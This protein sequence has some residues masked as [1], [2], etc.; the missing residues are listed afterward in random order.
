M[1]VTSKE[2]M[3]IREGETEDAE[4]IAYLSNQLDYPSSNQEIS[5]R[6]KNILGDKSHGIYVAQNADGDIVGWIHI[7]MI[8]LEVNESRALIGG[9]VVDTDHRTRGVGKLLLKEE[10]DWARNKRRSTL[11]VRSSVVRKEAHP[12]YEKLGFKRIKTQH[13]YLKKL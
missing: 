5:N 9:L 11:Y 12:F 13:V 4:R 10:E 7:F 3:H 2:N 6:I 1:A 8:H